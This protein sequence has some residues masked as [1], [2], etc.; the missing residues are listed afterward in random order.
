MEYFSNYTIINLNYDVM[1]KSLKHKI[2]LNGNKTLLYIMPKIISK[3]E[4]L[5]SDQLK[6]Y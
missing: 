2:Q 4:L 1:T 3:I 5:I 6:F